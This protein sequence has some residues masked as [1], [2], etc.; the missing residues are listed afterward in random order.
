MPQITATSAA[1]PS[2]CPQP[3]LARDRPPLPARAAYT[4]AATPVSEAPASA[5]RGMSGE[6]LRNRQA[7]PAS[8]GTRRSGRI[9]AIAS[10]LQSRE[11]AGVAVAERFVESLHEQ[12][13]HRDAGHQVEQHADLDHE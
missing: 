5:T 8:S 3:R 12:A 13:Q 1:S 9:H 11:A 10:A 6:P 4:N 7:M 2:A